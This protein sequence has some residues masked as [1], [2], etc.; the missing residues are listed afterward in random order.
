MPVGFQ[1]RTP[2]IQRV[3]QEL[4]GPLEATLAPYITAQGGITTVC[5]RL[6][7]GKSTLRYWLGTLGIRTIY[8][9]VGPAD[10]LVLKRG[11]RGG[12]D[13]ETV[14]GPSDQVA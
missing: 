9:A 1:K 14:V 3:E 10:A 4:G 8:V 7:I 2:L 5:Q 11:A 13:E 12:R 6:G